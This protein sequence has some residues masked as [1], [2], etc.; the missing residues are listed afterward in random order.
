MFEIKIT[1]I[2]EVLNFNVDMSGPQSMH[3]KVKT[4]TQCTL[5]VAN[6]CI[7]RVKTLLLIQNILFSVRAIKTFVY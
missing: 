1:L 7:E 5:C 2:N 4:E 3:L 6:Q